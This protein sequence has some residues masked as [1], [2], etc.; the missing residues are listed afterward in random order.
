[1]AS[2][3]GATRD[4]MTTMYS[5]NRMKTITPIEERRIVATQ[6]DPEAYDRAKLHDRNEDGAKSYIVKLVH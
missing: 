1:M 4:T 2:T 5:R 6:T 3:P